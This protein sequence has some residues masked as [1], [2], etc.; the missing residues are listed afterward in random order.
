MQKV[1]A[2]QAYLSQCHARWSPGEDSAAGIS[3][4][5]DTTDRKTSE[6]VDR[7]T[8]WTDLT[9][10]EAV[11]LIV[12]HEARLYLTKGHEEEEE[13]E[14]EAQR[15]RCFFLKRYALYKFTFTYMYKKTDFL[16]FHYNHL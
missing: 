6:E 9:L 16:Q 15:I 3:R 8:E 1:V 14:E 12:H 2:F 11:R 7:Q 10:C 13:E 5:H 4:R